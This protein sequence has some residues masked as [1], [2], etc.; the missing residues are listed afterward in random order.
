MARPTPV[1]PLVPSTMVP[2]RFRR[3][4]RSAA[5]II[6][7]PIRS[8]T[9]PPGLKNSAFTQ[10]GVRAESSTRRNLIIGVQ[11][12]V[13]RTFSYGLR[14]RMLSLIAVGSSAAHLHAI[15]LEADRKLGP[16]LDRMIAAP[17]RHE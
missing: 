13:S 10:I 11:P 9:E 8:L 6:A 4:S 12:M 16:H 7:R 15:H 17:P 3:P 1:L 5:S 14:L 2:P